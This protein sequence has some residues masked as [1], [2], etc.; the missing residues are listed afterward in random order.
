MRM[1]FSGAILTAE[2]AVAAV[3]AELRA[4]AAREEIHLRTLAARAGL[5]EGTVYA[6]ADGHRGATATTWRGILR[7]T[8]GL[9][10][11]VPPAVWRVGLGELLDAEVTAL[12]PEPL[13]V[14]RSQG[15]ACWLWRDGALWPTSA[16]DAAREEWP[17]QLRV[18]LP[19]ELLG[20]LRL[21][22]KRSQQAEEGGE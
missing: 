14:A 2:A 19:A 8:P 12:G 17:D 20:A 10:D 4:W 11:R 21:G 13:V 22:L 15:R 5:G 6:L 3:A 18:Y 1:R 7:V 16:D 9:I